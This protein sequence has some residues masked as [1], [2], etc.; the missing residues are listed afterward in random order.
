M[1]LGE[2]KRIV[3]SLC[4]IGR[5]GAIDMARNELTYVTVIIAV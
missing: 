1:I 2:T 3:K 4:Y 5:K